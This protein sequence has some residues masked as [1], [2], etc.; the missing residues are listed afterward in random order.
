M[1]G[2]LRAQLLALRAGAQALAAQ[3]DALLIALEPPAFSPTI[4]SVTGPCRHPATQRLP[5]GRMG[6]PGAWLC[7]ACGHESDAAATTD[8]VAPI[9]VS[10]RGG[11]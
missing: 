2:V 7:A 5:A 4:A 8:D 1:T 3:A 9:G 10:A 11:G 6:A